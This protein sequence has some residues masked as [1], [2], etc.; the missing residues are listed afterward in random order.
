MFDYLILSGGPVVWA[1]LS[2]SVLSL[3][4][5]LFKVWH[6]WSLRAPADAQINQGFE[7]LGQGL[8]MHAQLKLQRTAKSPRVALLE[9]ASK[10]LQ[11]SEVK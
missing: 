7:D 10:Q 1:L 3:N 4:V 6:L 9:Q 8:P 11:G 2:L 5:I